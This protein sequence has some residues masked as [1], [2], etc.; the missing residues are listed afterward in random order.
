MVGQVGGDGRGL[1]VRVR[2]VRKHRTSLA[3]GLGRYGDSATVGVRV[4]IWVGV[5]FN[6]ALR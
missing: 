6:S 5:M 1:G 2:A 3:L 4:R